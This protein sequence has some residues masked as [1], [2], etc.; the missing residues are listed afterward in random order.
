MRLR[1]LGTVAML[2]LAFA[3]AACGNRA[4]VRDEF[5]A[6]Q[7][8]FTAT[9]AVVQGDR[10]AA[11]PG[12]SL[13]TQA[14]PE[15]V[16]AAIAPLTGPL[17]ALIVLKKNES[18]V[19]LFEGRNGRHEHWVTP[20]GQTF[21]LMGGVLTG[22]RGLGYDL[23]SAEADGSADLIRRR[24]LGNTDKVMRFLDGSDDETPVAL[25]CTVSPRGAE[26]LTLL[27]GAVRH[28]TKMRE[29]CIS[30]RFTSNNFYWVDGRGTVV[31]SRQWAGAETGEIILQTLRE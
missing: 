9:R 29:T 14:Q 19:L 31:Q 22:T 10:A 17:K 13:L 16:R 2:G 25:K 21:T 12:T 30:G 15:Q 4:G 11:Q 6:A 23:M 28:T 3:V 24:T 27:T 18:A 1:M 5:A 7:A 20:S 8:V 26:T